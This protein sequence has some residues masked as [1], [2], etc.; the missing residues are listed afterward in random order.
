MW[1][2]QTA[3]GEHNSKTSSH[4][5]RSTLLVPE[6]L[7]LKAEWVVKCVGSVRGVLL[8][9]EIRIWALALDS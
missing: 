9:L 5:H 6:R 4:R 2:V 7:E 3:A 1:S 8:I